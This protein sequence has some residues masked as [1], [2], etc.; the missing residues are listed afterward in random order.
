MDSPQRYTSMEEGRVLNEILS[1]ISRAE[2]VEPR[3]L[4]PPLHNV[5]DPDAL[6]RLLRST[7]EPLHVTF[8]YRQWQVEVRVGDDTE[9]TILSDDR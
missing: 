1:T 8:P 9:V 6:E 4:T 5:I 3:E 2:D 7:D